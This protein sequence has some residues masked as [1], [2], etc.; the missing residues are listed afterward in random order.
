MR[1]KNNGH[2]AHIFMNVE[3]PGYASAEK[4]RAELI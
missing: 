4:M 1:T 2:G 3:M